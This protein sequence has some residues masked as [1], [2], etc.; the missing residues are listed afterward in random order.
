MRRRLDGYGEP[1]VS[2]RRASCSSANRRDHVQRR[3]SGQSFCS[4]PAEG[5]LRHRG[6][7][8]RSDRRQAR[9]R[10]V[11]ADG[12]SGRRDLC[13]RAALGSQPH[14]RRDV[15]GTHRRH[16]SQVR[17][18]RIDRRRLRARSRGALGRAAG[19]ADRRGRHRQC[20]AARR[21]LRRRLHF[22]VR[23]QRDLS[24]S[25]DVARAWRQGTT[26]CS[27]SRLVATTS[28]SPLSCAL[29]FL[30]RSFRSATLVRRPRRSPKAAGF[31]RA[32]PPTPPPTSPP[33][34]T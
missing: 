26:A 22:G 33:G 16:R 34:A 13:G 18:A 6:L 5:D 27:P 20:L 8:E 10:R 17:R 15:A 32:T 9:G 25:S 29:R 24:G 14:P 31:I 21:E 12:R 11:A 1:V 28:S 7:G 2:L 3:S 19:A 4:R 30:R 23:E